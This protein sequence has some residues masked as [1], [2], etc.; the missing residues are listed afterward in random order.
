LNLLAGKPMG[1]PP[2][3]VHLSFNP[4]QR[5]RRPVANHVGRDTHGRGSWRKHRDVRP[6]EAV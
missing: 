5:R 2:F 3:E 1:L 4:Q 6:S